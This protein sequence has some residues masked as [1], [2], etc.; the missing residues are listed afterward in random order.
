MKHKIL[1]MLLTN[2]KLDKLTRL[3]KSVEGF[4]P[5]D[6]IEIKPLIVVNTLNDNY[7]N[8]VKNAPFLVHD[9]FFYIMK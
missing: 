1:L 2:H 7:Y 6:S 4:I 3:V 5:D 9:Q 8:E